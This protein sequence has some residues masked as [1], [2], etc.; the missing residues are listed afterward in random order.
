MSSAKNTPALTFRQRQQLIW[1]LLAWAVFIIIYG[2]WVPLNFQSQ[3][4][5]EV[6]AVLWQWSA[7]DSLQAQRLD[8]AVNVLLTVPLGFGLALLW[9]SPYVRSPILVRIA[10]VLLVLPLSLLAEYGQGFLPGRSASLG[11]LLA[12]TVGTVLGLILHVRFGPRVQTWLATISSAMD[13]QSRA[14]HLLHGY[15]AALLLFAIMPLDLTLDVGELYHKWNG[16]KVI[17]LPFYGMHGTAIEIS[18]ELVT[19][20]LLWMPV[21]ALWRLNKPRQTIGVIVLRAVLL[22]LAIECA[23]LLVLSRTSDI[24]DVLLSAVGAAFGAMAV[25]HLQKISASGDEALRRIWRIGLSIWF[26]LVIVI[27]GMP[28]EL[29]WPPQGWSAFADAFTRVPFITY[30]R[31]DEFGALNEIL[32]KLLVFL[33][34]GLF[35]R[36]WLT[37]RTRIPSRIALVWLALLSLLLEA[38]QVLLPGRVAELTDALLATLGAILGWRLGGWLTD[39][40]YSLSLG[41]VGDVENRA[42]QDTPVPPRTN[43][44]WWRG[45]SIIWLTIALWL[46]ARIPGIPYNIPKLIP[47]DTIGLFAAL[48]LA[49]AIWW[50]AMLPVAIVLLSRVMTL[51]LWLLLHGLVTFAVLRSTVA[52][53]MLHKIIGSP[54]LAW[55]GLT[56]DLIRYLALHFALLLPLCGGALLIQVMRRAEA[57]AGFIYWLLLVLIMAKPLHWI[58]IEQAATDNLTELIR[59]GGSLSASSWL[60]LSITAAGVTVSAIANL[61]FEHRRR[62]S[63]LVLTVLSAIVTPIALLMGLEPVLIKYDQIFSALQFIL[64]ASRD[65]YASDSE[66]AVRYFLA[67]TIAVGTLA[68]LQIPWWRRVIKT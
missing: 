38:G 37:S 8:T 35:C 52:L 36:L 21:G 23:Q 5:T 62:S 41:T 13:T 67:W 16:G 66:L 58:I 22:A 43:P 26:V 11:D 15:L 63:L 54:V 27:Y 34:G 49:L 61:V 10:I 29:R 56:E 14:A 40:R 9:I 12:Q 2:S 17:L 42:W 7:W 6:W 48:G 19:D 31:R 68:W 3:D 57:L 45:L 4:P 55:P 50:I 33:P 28:F 32:R 53:P 46:L 65:A 18:Y 59:H 44:W 25:P 51:P 24:T 64:S 20:V 30:F 47:A 60:A 39:T 1:L